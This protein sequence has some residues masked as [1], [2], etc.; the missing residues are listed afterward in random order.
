MKGSVADQIA[1]AASRTFVGREAELAL[2]S[3][4]TADPPQFVVGFIHGPGGIGKSRLLSAALDTRGAD[5]AVV[6]LD[7]R[8][9]EPTPRG[10][11]RNLATSLGAEP[12]LD[13][14]VVALS[15][16]GGPA[17]IALDTY[18]TFGL[19]DAWVRQV[20]VPAMPQGVVLM[21][22][23]RDRPGAGW[24]TTPGWA[25]LVREVHLGPLTD[26]Q[27]LDLLRARGIEGDDA[28]R[29]ADF[30][31]GHPLALEL[32]AAAFNAEPEEPLRLRSPSRAIDQLLQ[33]VLNRLPPETIATIEAASK[34]RRVTEP[35]L[36]A[37]LASANVRD[38]FADLRRL[39]F[40]DE[41]VEGL[42]LH[43]VVR[44]AVS[45]DLAARDP[46]ADA[47]YR[48]RAL[49]FFMGQARRS[50]AETLWQATADLIYLIR[51]PVLRE[52][53]F[54]KRGSAHA[55]EPATPGDDA[56]I[57]EI[58]ATHESGDEADLL[59]QWWEHH[60]ETFSV[61]RSPAGTVD[62]FVQVAR[63]D[64]IDLQLLAADPVT[65]ACRR[66]LDDVPPTDGHQVLIMRRWLGR[67]TGELMSPAVAACWLDVKRVYM[68][69]RPNLSRLYTAMRELEAQS[70]VFLPLGFA[71]IDGAQ[72][73]GER[74]L[75]PAW[76]NFGEGS[77]DGWLSR[78]IDAEV[79]LSES[80]LGTAR[81]DS[82]TDALSA[83]EIEVLRL[84]ADGLSNRLIGERLFI[85]EKTAGR[86][87]SNIYGKLG[88]HTRAQATRIAA[89]S[90]LT[91]R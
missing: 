70:A 27:A 2:L 40:V 84:I 8:D 73:S 39:P 16:A 58:I 87:V 14:V 85:S 44:D 33:V 90:G 26:D 5:R 43:D 11:L 55:V 42:L 82:P 69:L 34:A 91:E 45:T 46:E 17:V 72:L 77:V 41:S 24:L 62:A 76:L 10:F 12:D 25:G 37:L 36:R 64:R 23:G 60:P 59:V 75:E 51:N 50:S 21:I 48:R 38:E 81:G 3:A 35:I 67:D 31:R 9:V 49:G 28:E 29:I 15:A 20:F 1:D 56:A 7:C 57:R 79:E 4:G 18:E 71:R 88:V 30:A 13:S 89:E 6:R 66:H 65:A 19:L 52:A 80:E 74:L 32:A 68:E 61:A 78:L 47:R 22:A 83:R 54:P 53:C 63:I 86:H